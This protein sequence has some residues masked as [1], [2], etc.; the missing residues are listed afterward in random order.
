MYQNNNGFADSV[1]NTVINTYTV[2]LAAGDTI[3]ITNTGTGGATLRP[4][5]FFQGNSVAATI[6]LIKIA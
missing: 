1:T 2:A 6:N 5:N 4:S 3:R